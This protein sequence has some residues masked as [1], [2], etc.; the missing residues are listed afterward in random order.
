MTDCTHPI[1]QY[2]TC[3]RLPQRHRCIDCGKEKEYVPDGAVMIGHAPGECDV[4]D[5]NS[6]IVSADQRE[7][8]IT[9]TMERRA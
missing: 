8:W 9:L 4:C 5:R 3:G 2:L 7:R 6:S 1:W